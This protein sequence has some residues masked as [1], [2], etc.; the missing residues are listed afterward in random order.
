[1]GIHHT[2]KSQRG[3]RSLRKQAKQAELQRKAQRRKQ[4]KQANN[5][6]KVYVVPEDEIVTLETLTT[7]NSSD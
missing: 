2:Y 5:D 1:M 6:S 3:E 7:P 4:Q